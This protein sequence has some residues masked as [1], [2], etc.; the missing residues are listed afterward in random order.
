P[1]LYERNRNQTV[2]LDRAHTDETE[3][4]TRLESMLGGTV[5]RL[6]VRRIDLVNDSTIVD[7]RYRMNGG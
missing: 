7:V 4:V 5:V 6:K 2:T 3:L 1:R